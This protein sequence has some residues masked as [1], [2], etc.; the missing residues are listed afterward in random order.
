MVQI[1]SGS[2]PDGVE[3]EITALDEQEAT[4]IDR[5]VKELVV[6]QKR[7]STESRASASG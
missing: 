2:A 5:W 7:R 1:S 3:S 6:N 4:A